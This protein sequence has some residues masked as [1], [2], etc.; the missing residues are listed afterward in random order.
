MESGRVLNPSKNQITVGF[1]P[2][3]YVYVLN[4]GSHSVCR[5]SAGSIYAEDMKPL[6]K[7]R[8]EAKKLKAAG[9]K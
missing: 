3:E 1:P 2:D 9:T 7:D 5:Y 4:I 6:S 8:K